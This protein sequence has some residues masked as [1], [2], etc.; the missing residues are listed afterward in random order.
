MMS[1]KKEVN[2]NN[3]RTLKII[4]IVYERDNVSD[5]VVMMW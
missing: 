1:G 3:T 5:D 4:I 2:N